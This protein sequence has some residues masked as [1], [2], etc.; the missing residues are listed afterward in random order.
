[1][2]QEVLLLELNWVIIILIVIVVIYNLVTEK[3]EE[4]QR[5]EK[6]NKFLQDIKFQIRVT[7]QTITKNESD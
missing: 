2:Y 5:K 1:M 4:E 7:E 6:V 3:E